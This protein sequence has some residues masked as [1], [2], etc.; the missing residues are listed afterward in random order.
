MITV[1]WLTESE[2]IGVCGEI[3]GEK[4]PSIVRNPGPIMKY[5]GSKNEIFGEARKPLP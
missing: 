3:F 1:F 5:W 4:P 2:E